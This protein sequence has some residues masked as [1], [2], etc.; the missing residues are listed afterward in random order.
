MPLD[1]ATPASERRLFPKVEI[2]MV[3]GEDESTD[4]QIREEIVHLFALVLGRK[5]SADGAEVNRA[6][7]LF[8][9]ILED[10]RERKGVEPIESYHCRST[11]GE[12]RDK[13]PKYAMRAWRGV[14]TY[15]LRQR[16]FLYE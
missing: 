14:V 16:E 1:F 7:D 11:P 3:P 9:G 10:A 13:D 12:G 5:E 6:Y 15:L 4:R 2:D 8:A